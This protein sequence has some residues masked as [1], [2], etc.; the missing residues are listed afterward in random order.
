MFQRYLSLKI[1]R[2][3][4]GYPRGNFS[5]GFEITF[6]VKCCDR[7]YERSCI[8]ESTKCSKPERFCRDMDMQR[9]SRD[10][11]EFNS[12]GQL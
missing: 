7:H 3:D 9:K 10:Q 11:S 2:V 8:I 12:L 4:E 5:N 1:G 6:V